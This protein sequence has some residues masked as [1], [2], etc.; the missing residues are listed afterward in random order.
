MQTSLVAG[1]A[2]FIGSHLCDQLLAD[3]YRVVC[4]DNLLTGSK[5]N[6]AHLLDREEF[7]FVEADITQEKTFVEQLVG[8]Y[9]FIF[10][11]ASPASPNQNS[12]MSYMAYP[13]ETMLVNSQGTYLL[14]ELA[15]KGQA[16]FLFAST[17][18]VYGDPHEH[19]QKETYWG[20]VNPNGIRSCYDE[21]KRFGEAMTMTYVRNF[22]V[23]ARMVRIFN[24]YGPRMDPE[25]GRAMVNFI[26][27]GLKYEPFTVYGDGTQTRS[28]C[29]VSD[30]VE[31][32]MRGMFTDAAR[33]EVVNLGNPDEYTMIQ[34]VEEICRKLG[35]EKEIKHSPLPQD[36]PQRRQPDI[37]KAKAMLAWEPK[38]GL[39]EGLEKTI[40]YF[41]DHLP[42]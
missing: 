25:D 7:V 32:I 36:D 13:V 6:I 39:G 42:K 30:L 33:G 10:H 26:V 5:K 16:K 21:S 35:R 38:V 24:T 34:L 18:E 2:G 22:D 9:D 20:N 28:F 29:Y 37:S 14:L 27:Q 3:G 31:G 12:A 8:K 15:K 17:S 40:A 41:K 23:N 4:V 19:P 11:L 1:G